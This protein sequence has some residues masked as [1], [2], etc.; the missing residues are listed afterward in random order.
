MKL[1]NRFRVAKGSVSLRRCQFGRSNCGCLDIQSVSLNDDGY[2]VAGPHLFYDREDEPVVVIDFIEIQILLENG[3]GSMN[4]YLQ[5]K[6]GS[7]NGLQSVGGL[8]YNPMIRIGVFD[9]YFDNR[10]DTPSWFTTDTGASVYVAVSVIRESILDTSRFFT[11][12]SVANSS[13]RFV[14]H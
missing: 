2:I 11:D 13:S 9:S 3:F 12:G 4:K 1:R 8:R 10:T 5:S 6:T 7:V 14:R